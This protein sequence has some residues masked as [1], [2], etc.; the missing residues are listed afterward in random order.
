MKTTCDLYDQYGD[1]LRVVPPLLND[2]GAR[3]SFYGKA[4]TVKCFEDN[5]R[6][7]ELVNTPGNGQVLVIDGGA[8]LRCALFGDVIAK[9]AVENGWAGVIVYGCVR[10]KA[11]LKTIDLGIKAIGATPRKS[12]KKGEGQ[13]GIPVVINGMP[14][15]PGDLVVADEDGVLFADPGLIEQ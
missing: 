2:F 11:M 12:T 14:C 15:K 13:V 3:T 9:E 4:V 10:D 8:S 5:S 7:K 1:Q 6:I